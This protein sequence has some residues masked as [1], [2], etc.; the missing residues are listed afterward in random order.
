M[1]RNAHRYFLVI[2]GVWSAAI[3][4]RR[5]VRTTIGFSS[6][7][8]DQA[9]DNSD[10]AGRQFMS[11]SAISSALAR[12]MV[13]DYADRKAQSEKDVEVRTAHHEAN[14]RSQ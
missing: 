6:P 11:L 10:Q 13:A 2:D 8:Y 5:E 3:E 14:E 12:A 1:W 9:Q 4:W 7:A